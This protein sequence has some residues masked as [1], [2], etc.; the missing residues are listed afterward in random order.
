MN[1]NLCDR[2]DWVLSQMDPRL[3]GVYELNNL[4]GAP[5]LKTLSQLLREVPEDYSRQES[6]W[7][8]KLGRVMLVIFPVLLIVGF[9]PVV[10]PYSLPLTLTAASIFFP[11]FLLGGR[12]IR[13][14]VAIWEKVV[15]QAQP[16]LEAFLEASAAFEGPFGVKDPPYTE[17]RAQSSL[18]SY[19]FRVLRDKQL[20]EAACEP[21]GRVIGRV[22]GFG[23]FY[24]RHEMELNKAIDQFKLFGLE[25]DK[26]RIFAA[27]AKMM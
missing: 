4:S 16:K 10:G 24:Q 17:Y 19:A 22:V 8:S 1:K 5:S 14:K 26:K 20:F 21:E 7:V 23:Q 18:E 13:M 9:L 11:I 15:N 25:F 27:A 2:V 3:V 12:K 6:N